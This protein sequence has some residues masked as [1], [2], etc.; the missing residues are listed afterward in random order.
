MKDNEN[1]IKGLSALFGRG[2]KRLPIGSVTKVAKI[3]GIQ[4]GKNFNELEGEV[5]ARLDGLSVSSDLPDS[6]GRLVKALERAEN[7]DLS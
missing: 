1:Q 7:T 5:C 2:E 4:T 6:I 3:L